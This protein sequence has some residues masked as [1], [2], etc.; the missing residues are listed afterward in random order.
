MIV[1]AS[2]ISPASMSD[3][4][5]VERYALDHHRLLL[6]A[7]ALHRR[8]VQPACEEH[9][10]VLVAESGRVVELDEQLEIVRRQADLLRQLARAR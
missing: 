5:I 9:V 1:L 2:V 10:R 4:T 6:D 8:L 3:G 7:V